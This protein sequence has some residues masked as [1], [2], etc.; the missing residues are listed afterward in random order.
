MVVIDG[1]LRRDLSGTTFRHTID[2]SN[3]EGA[4]CGGIVVQLG[5]QCIINHLRILLWDREPRRTYSYMVDLSMD[6]ND[7]YRVVD[8]SKYHCR[9]WQDLYFP[10]RVVRYIRIIGTHNSVNKIFH[11]VALEAFYTKREFQ[12]LTKNTLRFFSFSH[13]VS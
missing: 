12:V 13:R 7:W 9:S 3:T 10:P 6:Q 2:D 1:C 5:T 11:C 8:Y 4:G